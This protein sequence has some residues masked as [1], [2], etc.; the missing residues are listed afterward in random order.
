[1]SY[2]RSA[3]W[4]YPCGYNAGTAQS[5]RG[6]DL[7]LEKYKEQANSLCHQVHSIIW[8]LVWSRQFHVM[9]NVAQ[10]T[11]CCWQLFEILH[12]DAWSCCAY[13]DTKPDNWHLWSEREVCRQNLLNLVSV[14]WALTV[15]TSLEL[16]VDLAFNS[17]GKWWFF[18][19]AS[20]KWKWRSHFC[21]LLT[22]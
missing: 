2:T 18:F 12:R 9:S 19:F 16:I 21:N 8:L 6:I 14:S 20:L 5:R 3:W 7:F 4:A 17:K 22:L 1:M 11:Q 13:L 15:S 10:T